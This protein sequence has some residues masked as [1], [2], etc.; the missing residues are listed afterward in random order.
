MVTDEI[1]GR[2]DELGYLAAFLDRSDG[3]PRALVLEGEAG[4]GKSTLWTAGVAQAEE[5]GLRAL[6]SRPAEAERGFAHVVLAD[7]LEGVIQDVLPMLSAPRR[8]ALEG[9][10][11]VGNAA[12]DALDPRALAVATTRASNRPANSPAAN[13]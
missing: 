2:E 9:A 4:V 12:E 13:Q 10:L 8:R 5:H 1:V 6:M 3:G 11:L 7:L